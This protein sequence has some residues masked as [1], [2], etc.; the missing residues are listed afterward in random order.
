MQLRALRALFPALITDKQVPP[1][2]PVRARQSS[3]LTSAS[4]GPTG[5]DETNHFKHRYC[6]RC[7]SHSLVMQSKLQ[8]NY[9]K[10]V[11]PSRVCIL[12]GLPAGL[13]M[14]LPQ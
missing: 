3:Q 10:M 7:S 12:A 14:K 6:N 13:P 11:Q 1:A 4:M 8:W 2:E 9:V 5:T